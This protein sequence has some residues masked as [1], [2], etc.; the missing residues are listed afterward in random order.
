MLNI[1][2]TFTVYESV[3]QVYL[4]RLNIQHYSCWGCDTV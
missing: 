3:K 2:E 1:V 4:T